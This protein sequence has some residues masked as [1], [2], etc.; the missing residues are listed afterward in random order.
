M[1]KINVL[2]VVLL[3]ITFIA[4]QKKEEQKTNS[5][6]TEKV[7]TE[8]QTP[9][10]VSLNNGQPWEANPETT[11][12]IKALQ[13]LILASNTGE[14][15]AVLKEKLNVEFTIIFKKCTMT[16]EAHDQLHNYLLPLKHKINAIEEANKKPMQ[17]E[18]ASYLEQ[19]T[20]YFK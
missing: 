2:T 18:I 13:R 8:T 20:L 19:Y 10:K 15:A 4:C 9:P 14:S 16:G 3:S 11:S 6:N 17:Q 12:G 5:A 1:K 7:A